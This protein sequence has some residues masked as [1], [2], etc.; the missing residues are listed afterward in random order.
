[1]LPHIHRVIRRRTLCGLL[2]VFASIYI[3]VVF[4]PITTRA[5]AQNCATG[6]NGF[7]PLACTEGSSKL[8]QL[9][10]AEGLGD[11]VN[12]LFLFSL[13]IGAIMAIVRLMWGGYL[14]MGSGDMWS[15]KSRAREVLGDAVLGLLLLLAIY[16]ILFQINPDLLNLDVLKTIKNTG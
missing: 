15:S 13:T 12:K 2:V 8:G 4:L 9:Y 14:Y 6:A 5:A 16:L 3:L 7:V 1:M 11:Y 10:A